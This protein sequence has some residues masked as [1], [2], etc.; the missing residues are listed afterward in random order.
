MNFEV[1]TG[2]DLDDIQGL[3][4]R[5][6]PDLTAARYVLLQIGD[7]ARACKWLAELGNQVTPAPGR[8]ALQPFEH[9][10]YLCQFGTHPYMKVGRRVS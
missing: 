10:L 7:A 8:P 4:A 3:I 2:V 6:Y 1:T 9:P 5:G